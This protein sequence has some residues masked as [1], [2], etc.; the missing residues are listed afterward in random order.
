MRL[1]ELVR[2]NRSYRRFDQA[3]PIAIETLWELADLGRYCASAM[4]AQ[5][6][7]YALVADKDACAKVFDCL[8]WAGYLPEWPGPS[9]GE[10]PTGYVILLAH[11]KT[12]AWTRCDLGIAAQTV[13]LGAAER[14]LGGCMIGSVKKDQLAEI[15][16]LGPD[17][18]IEL[19]LALGTPV[20]DVTVED[21]GPQDEFKYW[22]D[23][24]GGHHVPKRLTRDVV[25]VSIPEPEAT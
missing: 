6:L 24:R 21:M 12:G 3:R 4:N 9:E 1:S 18:S 20:E 11:G 22:R 17:E 13:M 16:G 10:R 7:R 19:V 8:A 23:E 25:A 5:P 14:G 15:L 2:K